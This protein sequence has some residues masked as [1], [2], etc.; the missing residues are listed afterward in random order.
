MDPISSAP[1]FDNPEQL[2][3]IREKLKEYIKEHPLEYVIMPPELK[4]Y[5]KANPDIV[6]VEDGKILI[7]NK[8]IPPEFRDFI[9]GNEAFVITHFS[10]SGETPEN[11]PF[12]M[13]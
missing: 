13:K 6:R 9:K 5:L 3:Q 4:E 11:K 12:G 8:D 1:L 2:E 7:E 10:P